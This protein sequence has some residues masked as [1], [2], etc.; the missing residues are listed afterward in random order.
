[1]EDDECLYMTGV[2]Q[3][4]TLRPLASY[5][6][7][8]TTSTSFKEVCKDVPVDMNKIAV[9]NGTVY[10]LIGE[11]LNAIVDNRLRSVSFRYDSKASSELKFNLI[12]KYRDG[13]YLG[14]KSGVLPACVLK[15]KSTSS[16]RSLIDEYAPTE[17][18]VE[19]GRLIIL[20]NGL[21]ESNRYNDPALYI[22]N[23]DNLTKTMDVLKII[24]VISMGEKI[25]LDVTDR[26][27]ITGKNRETMLLYENDRIVNLVIGMQLKKWAE[28]DGSLV[29]AGYEPD[30]KKNKLYSYTSWFSELQNSFDSKYWNK[31]EN[32]LFVS[33]NNPDMKLAS[34]YRFYNG[35]LE[36]MRNNMEGLNV[37]KAKGSYYL[38]Y[39]FERDAAS[40]YKNMKIL[41]VYDE[42]SKRFVDM[43][44]NIELTHIIFV[45]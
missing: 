31:I 35:D 19:N 13:L 5:N 9:Y 15:F 11:K 3:E 7:K 40:R 32:K 37:I 21:S 14:L 24:N 6:G 2:W 16:V 39:A 38:V 44:V 41:Y 27:R 23:G 45:Q 28:M 34:L 29:F 25:F 12:K 8:T 1:M 10:A 33:G 26:D 4:G 36:L 17:F 22:Y 20:G 43:K 18:R 30:I 42:V